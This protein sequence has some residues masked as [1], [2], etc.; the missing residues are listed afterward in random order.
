MNLLE[1]YLHKISYKFPKGYPDLTQ[2]S[3]RLILENELNKL[4]TTIDL[5]EVKKDFSNLSSEAQK[6]GSFLM[7]KLNLPQDEIKS[8]NKNR[9]IIL[10]NTPRQEIFKNLEKLNYTKNQNIPG[11]SAGGYVSPEGVEV[12]HKSKS[13]TQVG[14]AGVENENIFVNTIN[15]YIDESTSNKINIKLIPSS[16]K[17]ITL[18]NITEAIHVGKEGEKKGWKG[19]AILKGSK[20]YSISLKKEGPFRWAS[21]MGDFK[22]FY[23]NFLEKASQKQIP[24]LTLKPD[25]ENPKVLQMWNPTNKKP[26]G[27]IFITDVPLLKNS[28]YLNKQIFGNDE[29][30]IVQQSF[31]PDD[32]VF[33]TK[34]NT[35]N[36]NIFKLITSLEEIDSNELPVLEFERNASKATSIKGLTGRGIILRLSP[37]ERMLKA[38]DKANN[39]ILKYKDIK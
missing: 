37:I 6:V 31:S 3:D 7:K 28:E 25:P 15:N 32:F 19:D 14:G 29:S 10:T 13:L 23:L 36:I 39:L 8:H 30:I 17:T 5:N 18:K 1:K 20:N 11:S 16:G 27:R 9:I 35:L 33:D 12:I 22:D 4:G 2:E 38:S 24:N 21:V 26:Y 34:T